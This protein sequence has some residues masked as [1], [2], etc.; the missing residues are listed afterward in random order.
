MALYLQDDYK[1]TP[2]LTL[3]LGLRWD[4]NI[5]NLPDQTNNRTIRLLKLLNH[6]RARAITGDDEKLSRTTPSWTEFQ[7]RFGF[8][9]DPK[10]TGRTVIRGGYGIFYDQLFQ[11][12]TLF[13]LTQSN[14]V[15]YQTI[16]NLSNTG[17]AAVPAGPLAGFRFGVDPLPAVPSDFSISNLAFGGFGRINDPDASEPYVQKFSL[18]IE[19]KLGDSMTLSSDY[20]HTLG[21]HESRVQVINPL[22]QNICDPLYPNST[23]ASPQCVRGASTRLFDRAFVDAGFPLRFPAGVTDPT[24]ASARVEQINMIGTTN[25]SLFDS[26]TTTFKYR[27]RKYLF[28]GSYV[29]ASSR[30]WGGQPVA[31]YS[32]NGIATTPENQFRPG[33]FGPTRLDERHRIVLSG[34]FELPGGFQLAPIMQLASSRPFSPTTGVDIDGDGLATNDRLCANADLAAV[35]AVRGNSTAVRALNP[36]GCTQANVN[37]LRSGFVVDSTGAI[38]E[39][40]N[41]FFNLDLRV[42]KAFSFGER[43]KLNAYADIYNV[44]N[45]ENL[46]LANRFHLSPATSSGAF[47]QPVSLFGPGFGPPVGRPLTLQLGARLTF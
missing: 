28:S 26:W 25:R 41:R 20:V 42:N 19:T 33:E 4:A 37:S 32:G 15:L 7:P 39:R 29:L 27:T 2:N 30:S 38:S 11:N 1:V 22:I 23:P 40:G 21:L 6:P 46:A 45:V 17:T 3:N 16:I 47:L 44:F 9:W 34:V 36:R 8:A 13:S 24:R 43:I 18:G 10:G 5:G 31:S 35:F 14:P 12:L